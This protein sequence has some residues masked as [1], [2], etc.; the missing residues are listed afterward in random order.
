[1]G[2]VFLCDGRLMLWCEEIRSQWF[3]SPEEIEYN[4]QSDKSKVFCAGICL[5]NFLHCV[6]EK[7]SKKKREKKGPEI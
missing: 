5:V 3:R 1:M 6:Y 2:R 7:D 4:K